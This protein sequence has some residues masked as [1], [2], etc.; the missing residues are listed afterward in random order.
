MVYLFTCLYFQSDLRKL[1]LNRPILIQGCLSYD[2]SDFQLFLLQWIWVLYN[3]LDS[4][5]WIWTRIIWLR[6]IVMLRIWFSDGMC[7]KV[8]HQIELLKRIFLLFKMMEMCLILTF[9]KIVVVGQKNWFISVT[10]SCFM[11]ELLWR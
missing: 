9:W 3:R 7:P 11:T 2:C 8:E 4:S 1:R 5:I 6:S 10:I